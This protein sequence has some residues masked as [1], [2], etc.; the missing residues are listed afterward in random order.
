MTSSMPRGIDRE[1]WNGTGTGGDTRSLWRSIWHGN[2]SEKEYEYSEPLVKLQ[3]LRAVTLMSALSWTSHA[4]YFVLI[5]D[6]DVTVTTQK[7]SV[8]W[9]KQTPGIRRN[10]VVH[11]LS[12]CYRQRKGCSDLS[13]LKTEL[14]KE[15]EKDWCTVNNT[16]VRIGILYHLP[17]SHWSQ[18]LPDDN[19]DLYNHFSGKKSFLNLHRIYIDLLLL[20]A[21]FHVIGWRDPLYFSL[22]SIMVLSL[23]MRLPQAC[24]AVLHPLPYW[25]RHS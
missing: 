23:K 3:T 16:I 5:S 8:N 19:L 2:A 18:T 17:S 4:I 11:G 20:R 25:R 12:C 1:K 24:L 9:S 7:L 13:F 21:S 10:F 15:C 6:N 14:C 22:F